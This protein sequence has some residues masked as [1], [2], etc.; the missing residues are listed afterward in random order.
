MMRSWASAGGVFSWVRFTLRDVRDELRDA[1]AFLLGEV[2]V[3]VG[4]ELLEPV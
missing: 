1:R 4:G 3:H 2:E